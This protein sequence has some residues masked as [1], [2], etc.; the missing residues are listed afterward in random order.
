MTNTYSLYRRSFAPAA[1]V[2]TLICSLC[3]CAAIPASAQSLLRQLSQDSFTN[4]SSQHMTEVEPG[5]FSYGATIVTA[6]QVGRIYGGGSADIGFATSI[7]GGIAWT[8]GYLPGLTQWY[9]GGSNSAASDASVAYDLKHN[10]W[11]ISTLPIGNNNLVAVSRS[12]D[13]LHWDNP[14]YVTNSINSDK[15]WINC[16]NTPTSP[17][18]GNCYVEFDS[19]ADGDLIFMST[20]SDGGL[21]WGPPLNTAAGD[22]GLGGNPVVQPNGTVVVGY[23]DFNG[24]MSAF[25]SNNGGHS[26]NAAVSISSAPMHGLAGGLRSFG[27]PS[28]A[29]DG[30][31]TVYVS[32]PDCRF[33]SGC[34]ANDIVFST[35]NDG[36][37]WSS[38]VRVASDPIGS[39]VDH[40][41][42][43]MGIDPKTSGSTA[44]LAVTYYFYPVANCGNSCTLYAGYTQSSDGGKTW[45]AGRQ[46]SG[47]MQIS[48]LPSTLSGYMVADYVATVF[49]GPRA[50]PLYVIAHPP[51][52]GLL[53][54]AVYTEGYGFPF[55]GQEQTFSSKDDKPIP[56]FNSYIRPREFY[57]QD[58]E[59]PVHPAKTVPPD[60]R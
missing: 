38:V 24:G 1:L 35:S 32:W 14:I 55:T 29:I 15:D 47:G 5:A 20:S 10:E 9:E 22:Y 23:A 57:D 52:G 50:F 2:L 30:A 40:F 51:S 19:P 13:A 59:F 45:T 48:W 34:S 8:N 25:T 6:F 11:L 3:L 12:S 39:G 43:G 36:V 49:A 54:E 16:D 33:E 46:L 56:D 44:H 4:G 28:T 26:W 58:N 27:L 31:G 18:Y 7:N 41:I 17:Y 53:Q 21:T 37:H 60:N 42:H